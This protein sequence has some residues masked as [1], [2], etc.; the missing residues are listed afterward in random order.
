MTR[1]SIAGLDPDEMLAWTEMAETPV[2]VSRVW[3][4]HLRL[5]RLLFLNAEGGQV[6]EANWVSG[7]RYA[8]EEEARMRRSLAG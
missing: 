4:P 2:A 3:D 7:R 8:D 1:Y 5:W 6:G